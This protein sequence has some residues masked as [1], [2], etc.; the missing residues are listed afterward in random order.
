MDRHCVCDLEADNLLDEAAIIW[1]A[2]FKDIK[3][4]ETVSFDIRNKNFRE[5]VC[6]YMDGCSVLAMHNGHGYDWPLLEKLWGYVYRGQKIDTLIWSRAQDT[7]RYSA[8]VP[9]SPHSVEAWGHRFGREKPEHEDW[10][11]FSEDMLHRCHEDTEIQWMIFHE[12]LKEA[13]PY[14]WKDAHRLNN[15]LF[16]FLH[17]QE[18]YG[19]KVDPVHMHKSIHILGHWITR[20]DKVLASTLPLVVDVG[21]GKKKDD[22]NYIKK[23]FKKDG[24]YSKHV[25]T[26][27]ASS[28]MA[29][30][31]V[32]PCKCVTGV[33]SRVNFR[34]TNLNSNTETKE[35]LLND[36]WEPKE[37]N[38]ND[39]GERTS[40]KLSK[41]DPFI[42]ISGGV[43]R[44]V[45][46]RVQ[47]NHRKSSI[48]GWLLLI[49]PDGRI[50]SVVNSIAAT[51]RAKHRGVVN[52]PNG[53]A[54]FGKWMRQCFI[55]DVGKTLVGCDSAGCQN[56]M[57]AARVGNAG[58]TRTLLEGK[59]EDKTS[60][61]YVN[62]Q[63]IEK[64]LQ[65]EITYG[66]A[67]N[68]NYAFMFGSGDAKLGRMVGGGTEEGVLVRRAMLSVAPG[69]AELIHSLTAEWKKNAKRQYNPKWNK[70][71]WRNGWIKGLDGRPI[72]IDSE[73]K[74]LVFMLQSD[75]A[76]MMAAA[77][78]LANKKLRAKYTYG[79]QFGVVCWMHDEVTVECDLD[80]AEDVGKIMEQCIADAG[81]FYN[82]ACPHEGE[83]AI[84]KDWFQIH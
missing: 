30:S 67:K 62:K 20:I 5:Q 10:S 82:I 21:K 76:I 14:N 48:E 9:R 17:D 58:F 73:H 72:H 13:A 39:A 57:L 41:D 43:G 19:W 3:T 32:G 50:A 2:V 64:F 44:L 77:Y 15:K 1:C 33:F 38:Y 68:L 56:R 37:W 46:K 28:G 65:K 18:V 70:T 74:I 16:E 47:C 75:E 49:R 40:A 27:I 83:S 84:G 31:S 66:L 79:E 80:I 25:G 71:E 12:L 24:S 69:F 55:S 8:R 59:K 45:A 26:Y 42:G 4:G 51:G 6:N 23:P 81:N 7:K 29:V 60:I 36:G 11:R 22:K 78:V 34:R 61:H 53:E 63:A 54:F 35:M 52:V